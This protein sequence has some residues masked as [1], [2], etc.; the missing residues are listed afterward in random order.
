V[1]ADLAAFA[2]LHDAPPIEGVHSIELDGCREKQ[3]RV[4][5]HGISNAGLMPRMA[6]AFSVTQTR[7]A[8]KVCVRF[9]HFAERLVA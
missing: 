5:T 1:H 9:L 3:G 4:G 2:S 6:P 7:A 8:A